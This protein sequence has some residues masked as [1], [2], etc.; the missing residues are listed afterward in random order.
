MTFAIDGV[1]TGAEDTTAPYSLS[2]SSAAVPNG[3]HGVTAIARDAAGNSVVSAAVAISVDNDVT[4][5]TVAVTAPGGGA[6]VTGTTALS[7]TADDDVDVAGVRFRIDGVA[8]GAE[9]TSLAYSSPGTA[10]P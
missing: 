4:A 10:R 6:S 5:P 7:A 2:W 8:V 1:V 9:D 3:P